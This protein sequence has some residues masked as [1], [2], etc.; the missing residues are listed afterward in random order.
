MDRQVATADQRVA[1]IAGRQ[2]GVITVDQLLAAGLSN[3]QVEDR[4]HAGRLHRVH[5][6]VYRV[7]HTAPS[8]EADYLAAVL[9]C[10]P[11]AFLAGAAP[12]TCCGCCED[13][14][15]RRRSSSPPGG[16]TRHRCPPG[17]TR[18]A[19]HDDLSPDPDAHRPRHPRGSRRTHNRRRAERGGPA[20]GRLPQRHP[21]RG[22]RSRGP[23]RPFPGIARLRALYTGDEPILLS[24]LERHFHTLLVE[25]G[26]P[27]PI[28]NRRTDAH[29]VDCRWPQHHLTVELDSYRFHHSR[30]A[31]EEDKQRERE[32]RTR[33]SPPLHLVRRRRGSVIPARRSRQPAPPRRYPS[34]ATA[35]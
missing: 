8:T 6:G 5:R 29:Y 1:Q 14:R 32:A 2:H 19:R 34:P 27:R 22:R 28:T 12:A 16:T 3:R 26:F 20:G 18:P 9:A 15:A 23:P 10:E 4:A 30:K 11:G 24:R 17:P 13:V 35:R 7:G 21:R 31:W 25:N 33:A